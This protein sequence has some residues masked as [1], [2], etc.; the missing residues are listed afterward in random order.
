MCRA[1]LVVS[2]EDSEVS[3]A[4]YDLVQQSVCRA[5]GAVPQQV[6]RYVSVLQARPLLSQHSLNKG[7]RFF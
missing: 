2:V 6:A 4:Q 7:V 5:V 3:N 1:D